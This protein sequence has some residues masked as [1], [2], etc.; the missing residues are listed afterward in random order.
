VSQVQ[1]IFYRPDAQEMFTFRNFM[2]TYQQIAIKMSFIGFS[3][4]LRLFSDF[5][6]F[7]IDQ[8]DGFAHHIEVRCSADLNSFVIRFLT[9]FGLLSVCA[10]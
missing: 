2:D 6:S 9:A 5:A 7:N 4:Q 1:R 10:V 3:F 8:L